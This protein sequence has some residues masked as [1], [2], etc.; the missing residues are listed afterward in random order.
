MSDDKAAEALRPV[1]PNREH[2][3]A[4]RAARR[5]AH[6]ALDEIE[7][8]AAN[9]RRRLK[10]ADNPLSSLDGD[11]A[12]LLAGQ[13][14]ALTAE[15]AIIGILR[16]VREWHQADRADA[17]RDAE[18]AWRRWLAEEADDA[19]A[20]VIDAGS[21]EQEGIFKDAFMAARGVAPWMDGKAKEKS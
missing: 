5:R 9:L 14:R 21:E 15:L 4:D 3:N 16:D 19:I 6:K 8:E 1:Y 7:A 11:D 18:S 13:L 20:G 2:A 12:Q 10:L 17:E